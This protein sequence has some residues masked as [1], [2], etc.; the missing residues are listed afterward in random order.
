MFCCPLCGR[1]GWGVIVP[2]SEQNQQE[3][4][5][6]ICYLC[7]NLKV[8]M[9]RVIYQPRGGVYP[10]IM[11]PSGANR[12]KL[13]NIVHIR[14]HPITPSIEENLLKEARDLLAKEKDF[15]AEGKDAQEMDIDNSLFKVL[16]PET[17]ETTQKQRNSWKVAGNV[18]MAANGFK[19]KNKSTSCVLL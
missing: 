10:V 16:V 19:R 18:I 7:I 13:G 14:S 2:V 11:L 6:I 15:K 4:R 3:D 5:L 17:E 1:I 8:A 12:A 9:T